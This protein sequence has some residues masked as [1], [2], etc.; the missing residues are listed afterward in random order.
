VSSASVK[1]TG[2][3]SL[4]QAITRLPASVTAALKAEA[5]A[6]ADRITA[7]AQALLRAQ[8]HGTGATAGAIGVADDSAH[9]QFTVHVSPEDRPANLPMWLEYGTRFLVAR[10]FMRPAAAAENDRYVQNMT[11]AAERTAKDV[12]E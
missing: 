7:H 1:T 10:P 12:L 8:T 9:Q 5:R 11:V 6:S 2:L 4:Q 3:D